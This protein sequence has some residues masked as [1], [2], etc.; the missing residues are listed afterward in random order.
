MNAVDF[1]IYCSHPR[2]RNR[3]AKYKLAAEWSVGDYSEL[4][5]YGFADDGCIEDVYRDA[6]ERMKKF[7]GC[8]GESVGDL[9]IYILD[10]RRRDHE[11]DRAFELEKRLAGVS[12]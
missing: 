4:K 9:R 8:E 11:L 10:S 1:T 3:P 6:R 12:S 2:A 5:T 7:R